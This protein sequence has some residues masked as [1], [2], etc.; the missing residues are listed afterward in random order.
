MSV[1][2]DVTFTTK[3]NGSDYGYTYT[4]A[5]FAGTDDAYFYLPDGSYVI[6]GTNGKSLGGTINGA[7]ATFV[8]VPEPAFV[9]LALLALAS[10]LRRK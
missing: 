3:R 1:A 9:A 7:D 5:G 10:L 6:T 4:G 8:T 2:E